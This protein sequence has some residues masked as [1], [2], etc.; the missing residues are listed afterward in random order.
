MITNLFK[1]NYESILPDITLQGEHK[2]L[3]LSFS[4]SNKPGYVTVV[5]KDGN[6]TNELQVHILY[7]ST[8]CSDINDRFATIKKEYYNHLQLRSVF[9]N[10]RHLAFMNKIDDIYFKISYIDNKF[11]FNIED[12]LGLHTFELDLSNETFELLNSTTDD[13]EIKTYVAHCIASSI[14]KELD[15]L[16]PE[17]LIVL[18]NYIDSKLS[19]SKDAFNKIYNL[20]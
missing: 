8:F 5:L 17:D 10:I 11:F 19:I 13:K 6:H 20:I 18:A 1:R 7:L 14:S 15:H 2:N 4:T 16:E 3:L 9:L 12:I